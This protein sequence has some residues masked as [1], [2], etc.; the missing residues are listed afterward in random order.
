MG[1]YGRRI[2]RL[3]HPFLP[4][5]FKCLYLRSC[6]KSCQE[7]LFVH[8]LNC[9]FLVYLLLEMTLYSSYVFNFP[10]YVYF[11]CHCSLAKK[12]ARSEED[13]NKLTFLIGKRF[14]LFIAI[15]SSWKVPIMCPAN[16]NSDFNYGPQ[17]T[18]YSIKHLPPRNSSPSSTPSQSFL[19]ILNPVLFAVNFK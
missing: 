6:L 11:R 7:Y 5:D 14:I 18:M 9:L 1:L 17:N 10:S 12:T 19:T 13:Y 4:L 3:W 8:S 16:G 15:F 2:F